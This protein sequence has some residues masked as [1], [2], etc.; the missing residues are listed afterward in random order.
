MLFEIMVTRWDI[1]LIY[2]LVADIPNS[3]GRWICLQESLCSPLSFSWKIL[4]LMKN[5]MRD[6]MNGGQAVA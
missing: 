4:I 5:L 2:A 1:I 3:T 6:I